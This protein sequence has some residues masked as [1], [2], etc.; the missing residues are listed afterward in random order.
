MNKSQ[1]I[2]ILYISN[3]NSI[4]TQRW[5][6][7][8]AKQ[9]YDTTLIADTPLQSSYSKVKVIDLTRRFNFRVVRFIYWAFWLRRLISQINPDILHAHRVSSAGWLAWISGFHPLVVTPWGSDLLTHPA[10]S[11]IAKILARFVLNHAD[12]ITVNS[13]LLREKAIYYGANPEIIHTI[14]WG[15]DLD[16]FYPSQ[17]S[18]DLK[19]RLKIGGSPMILSLRAINPIYNIETIVQAIPY[20]LEKYPDA[21]FVFLNYNADPLYLAGLKQLVHGLQLSNHVRWVGMITQRSEFAQLL[22]LADAVVSVPS[23]DSTPSSMLE[24]MATGAPIIA[25]DLP[26]IREWI[27]D[28]INGILVPPGDEHALASGI[29]NL[30][31][32]P[33]LCNSFKEYNLQLVRERADHQAEMKKME[34]LYLNLLTKY[35]QQP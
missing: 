15:V 14:Q 2:K 4:H 31:S 21:I 29:I 25:S 26:S 32:E 20:V 11:K 19:Q 5:I 10:R 9:G 16:I 13:T 1:A 28:G 6:N 27:T 30:L 12:L 8:F 17:N 18:T 35:K 23:S 22:C 3:P 33:E 34:A 24:A 7:W